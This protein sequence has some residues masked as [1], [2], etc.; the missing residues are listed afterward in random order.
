MVVPRRLYSHTQLWSA[1]CV[2]SLAGSLKK[3]QVEV[4]DTIPHS[5]IFHQVKHYITRH[6]L[7]SR[8]NV[9]TI[10]TQSVD[11][12]CFDFT[13]FLSAPVQRHSHHATSSVRMR[14]LRI[15]DRGSE[16][17]EDRWQRSLQTVVYGLRKLVATHSLTPPP[18]RHLADVA[19]CLRHKKKKSENWLGNNLA[20]KVLRRASPKKAKIP[21]ESCSFRRKQSIG[22][23][24]TKSRPS[25]TV[26]AS[27][28]EPLTTRY[29]DTSTIH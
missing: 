25:G 26:A 20:I 22:Q 21:G 3:Q 6:T 13:G 24:A 5:E 9:I 17:M 4:R 1:R 8:A 12:I 16:M 15:A 27:R 11:H 10:A 19:R 2:S 7:P 23:P 29:C 14:E 28:H 18:S